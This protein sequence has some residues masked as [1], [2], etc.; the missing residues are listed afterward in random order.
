MNAIFFAVFAFAALVAILVDGIDAGF[1]AL[2]FRF[3]VQP[4]MAGGDEGLGD[5]ADGLDEIAAFL[6]GK[7]RVGFAL[8]E[9]DVRVVAH[10]DVK[11]AMG[12][13]FLEEPDV[14]GMK[15]IEA[16]GDDDLFAR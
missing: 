16:A 4:A 14:A 3:G 6:L 13:D 11:I 10:D 2:N 7:E 15:P 1:D 5:E 9:T 12:A 8:E